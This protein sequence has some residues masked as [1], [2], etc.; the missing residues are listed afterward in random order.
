MRKSFI[1]PPFWCRVSI[2]TV[3]VF[4]FYGCLV[5]NS[6][7]KQ[8]GF[9]NVSLVL[10]KAE[11]AL[12]KRASSDTTFSLDSILVTFTAPGAAT[13]SYRYSISGRPDTGAIALPNHVFAL[14]PLRKWTMRVLTIDTTL[15]PIRRDTVH[16]DSVTF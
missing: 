10:A 5:S 9:A 8:S 7:N 6:R 13:Q 14:N 3:A 12:G 4:L 16:L 1:H 15:S 2:I 11:Q